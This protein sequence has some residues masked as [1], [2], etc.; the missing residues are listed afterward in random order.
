MWLALKPGIK[1][2]E[3]QTETVIFHNQISEVTDHHFCHFCH[4]LLVVK[5]NFAVMW[6]GITQEK[7][8]RR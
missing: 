4:I 8:T 7:N 1:E 3:P 2:T 6:E 5:T